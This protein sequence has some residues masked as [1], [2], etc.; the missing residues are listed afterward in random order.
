MLTQRETLVGGYNHPSTIS[1]SAAQ[2]TS[3]PFTPFCESMDC[4]NKSSTFL[5]SLLFP[6]FFFR[7]SLYV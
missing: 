4:R 5:F 6:Y 3:I 2:K 7:P 1:T